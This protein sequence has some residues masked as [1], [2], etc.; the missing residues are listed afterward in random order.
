MQNYPEELRTPPVR[1]ISLVGCPDL[2]PTISNHLLSEQ[3]PIH[4]LAFPDL[5]NISFLLPLPSSKESSEPSLSTPPPGILKRDWLL[6]RRTKV[7]AVVAALFPSL[8]VSGDPAQWLQ[9]CSDL[10]HLKAVTR[11][12]NIKLVVIIVH[13]DSKDDIN[14]DRM[15][16]LRKRAEVDTKYVIFV[17]PND[18]SDLSQSLHRLRN[19]FSELANVYYKDEGR[20]LK[21]RIEK[22]TSSY[23]E[24]NIRYCFK[25][26]VYAEFLSDW[27]EALRFYEDAY[28]KLWEISG[29]PTRSLSIQRLVEIKTV[30][31]QLHFKISTLLLHSGKVVE[32]VT[33]FRQHITLY[34]RLIGEPDT[35]FL[36]WE[37]MSRQFM[38]FAELLE[39]SSTTSLSIPALGLGTGNKPLTEWEFHSAYYYQLAANYLKEKRSSFEL[40]SSMYINADELEKTTESLVPS[41]Y[42]GQYC[43]LLEQVDVT[44]MQTV[45]DKAFLNNTIAGEKKHQEPFH[46]ITLLKKAYESYSHAKAQRMSSFCACQIAKEHY[47]MD[48]LEEAK[49]HFDNVASLYR[50]EGW[51]TLLWE[52]LSYLRD[53]SRKHGI[54]KDYL[55]YSLEM[56]ALP[57]SFDVHMLS[58]RSKDCCPVNPA[59]LDNREKIHNEIFNLV[60][61]ESVLASVEHGKELKVTGDNPVHLEI[62]L[63]SP[64]RLVLLA[65][66]A[67]HEQVIKPGVP[68]LITVSL[69]SHLPLTIELDQLEV[70]FNQSECNFIVVNAERLPSAGMAS[71]Q[72]GHRVEQAPSLALSSNKWLRMTY[73]IKSDQSGKLECTSVI[74]KIRPNFTIC[75]RAESPASMDDLPVWKF[76]NHLETLPTKDPALAFSGLKTIQVEELDPEVDLILSASTPA[77]VGETFIVP[78]TVVSKG[79]DIHSGELKINLV[80]VRG[81]GLFSPRE[82]ESFS[83]SHHVELLG[84]S[85]MEDNADSHL[86]SDEAM[87]IKQS[88]G[89]I[90]VPFLK[91]GEPWSCKL[92]IKWHRAKPIMLYVSLGYSPLSDDPNA[93][94]INVHRS[95]QIDGKPA[96]TIGHH[97]LLPFRRDALLLSRTKAIPQS[98]Q[99]LSLPLNET[100]ILVISAQNC[101]EVPLQLLSMSIEADNDGTEE[102]SCSIKNASSNLVDPALLTPG[103]EFKKVFTV[104]S[105]I[106]S[107]KQIRLGNVLLRWKRYSKTEDQYDSNVGSVLTTQSLPDVDTEFSPLI[108][109]MES[110]PY[111]ILGDPFTYFIKIKN[112][113]KLLQEVKFSLADVQSFVISGSHDDTISILPVSEHVLGYKLVPLASGMLQ[114]PRFTLTSARYSASFQPSMAESTVFVFPSKPPCELADKG[115]AGP[116]SSG[117]ISTSLS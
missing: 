12:R 18:A 20:K 66:V 94:K 65:S 109:C 24:L 31:E 25:A 84:I 7:P 43:R 99:S 100:C 69:L 110:P 81:G 98:D 29:L 48:N 92:Q 40:I 17:K 51:I 11:S 105:E 67:F 32:A 85:G 4:T 53:L 63:V 46:M 89:L 70:H 72:H 26:A 117:P 14:E 56:A 27:I 55:E 91:P 8:H 3:P 86:I 77:L 74:A 54:V 78:V 97:I 21:T 15:I 57:I 30:A 59:T 95:L 60:D 80:D 82:T 16:A 114:L 9:L 73:Q 28:N 47:A 76:E 2:H 62:D 113:S 106:N 58:L 41:V 90:S 116:E 6:K 44:L 102:K 52:V 23:T 64:L 101:T 111:A 39:T 87:K 115:D 42:V 112:Q 13:S 68:T 35:E 5:S 61:E 19:S 79:P 83:S 45:T 71:D 50:R 1:L 38:V 96:V 10:D 107:S 34:S 93:Q 108:V 22:R 36:H 88:F 103:E 49:R 33:W 104:T 75:C 37:W